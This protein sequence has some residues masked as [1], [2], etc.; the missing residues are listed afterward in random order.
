[1]QTTPQPEPFVGDDTSLD[2]L[3]GRWVRYNHT[4]VP[5]LDAPSAVKVIARREVTRGEHAPPFKLVFGPIFGMDTV[6]AA[7]EAV[8][9]CNDSSAS[10]LLCLSRSATPGLYLSGAADVDVDGGGIHVN[11]TAIGHH[12]RDAAWVSGSTLLDCGFVNVVGGI[13]PPPD[14]SDWEGIFEGGDETVHGFPVSDYSDEV[15][16]VDDPLAGQMLLDGDPYVDSATGDHLELPDLIDSGVF[17]TRQAPGDPLITETCSLAPGYYPNGIRLTT[18]GV[19]VTLDPTL[20]PAV[21]PIYIFGGGRPSDPK[22]GMYINGGNLQIH[23]PIG[24]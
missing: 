14:S 24:G 13:T 4:F 8:A 9:W 3:V 12:S 10:G 15:A 17:P 21:P 23:P 20:D 22:C 18:A 7:R 1:M 6:D 19:T 2:I 5:T 11:S 16:H